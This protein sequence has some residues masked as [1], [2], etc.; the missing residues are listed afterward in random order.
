MTRALNFAPGLDLRW[1]QSESVAMTW[2]YL[3]EQAGNPVIVIPTGGG[4]SIILAKLAL[5]ALGWGA[6][7]LILAHRKE[8]LEQNA[9]K[10][11]ALM[12]GCSVGLF[13]SGLRRWDSESDV[14]CAGI[15]SV[16]KKAE[17][18]TD[19]SLILVDE[20]HLVA[21]NGEGMYRQFLDG[22]LS[23]N[24]KARVVGLTA[25]PFRTG[26]GSL[27]GPDKLFQGV[28]YEA[29]IPRLIECGFLSP[30]TSTPAEHHADTSKLHIRGGEFVAGEVEQLFGDMAL[31]RSACA[32]IAAKTQDR[33]S[34]ICFAAGVN[35]ADTVAQEIERLTGQPVGVVTGQTN[36]LERSAHLR[37]FRNGTLRWLVNVDVL[38]TGFDAPNIDA[39][40]VL[41]ATCS[42]GLFAQICG[43]GFRLAPGKTDC[44]VLDFGEN[45]ERHGP[46]DAENYGRQ[47]RR[48]RKGNEPSDAPEKSC[49]A[50]DKRLPLS[51]KECECGFRF[52]PTPRHEEAAGSAEL[53]ASM[54]PP[55]RWLVEA[56]SMRLHINE[57]KQSR[58]LRVDYECQSAERSGNLTKET[59][60]EWI[61]LEH[62][63][64]A[65]R[66]AFDW[67]KARSLKEVYSIEEAIDAWKL[68][69][70]AFPEWVETRREGK[71]YR[72]V[73]YA[74]LVIPQPDEWR[75]A[76]E[77]EAEKQEEADAWAAWG[78]GDEIPF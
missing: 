72:V 46:L 42:P 4:K 63:G 58:S 28:S 16:W 78:G 50:C 9:D 11:R 30:I 49:P 53:L 19:R 52:P 39:I 17:H 65:G 22:I 7:S 68:G 61:C 74:P 54:Q 3:C 66:K 37:A 47:E 44:L 43:R 21:T 18:F 27:C 10:V 29:K 32:E 6:K 8:L 13:S 75:D 20:A 73:K 70:V 24:Q 55:Q 45:V 34:I 14:V 36:D 60:S 51:A 12:P 40:A 77:L 62:E 76:N 31:V 38:T 23:I 48:T 41:R 15:Q 2:H 5:D 56:I 35:H 25:T 57:K 26:E 33:R 67:W 69:A 1:Y 71:W 59:I 64:F